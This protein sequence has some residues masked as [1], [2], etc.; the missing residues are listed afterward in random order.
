MGRV[1][2]YNISMSLD[3]YMAGPAQSRDDPLGIGGERLH[4]WVVGTAS[5]RRSHGLQGGSMGVDDDIAGERAGAGGAT[6]MG[7]NMF[8]PIR[9]EWGDE[10]WTGWWGDDPPFHHPVFVLTHHPHDP[11]AM[12]GGTNASCVA[13][14]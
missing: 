9:G 13:T 4:D 2:A 10:G 3:G 12:A 1:A 14:V 8:G 11:I 7:R 5:W 6:V